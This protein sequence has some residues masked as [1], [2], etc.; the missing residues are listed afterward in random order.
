MLGN[1]HILFLYDNELSGE[2]PVEIDYSSNL[3]MIDFFETG[4][5]PASLGSCHQLTILDLVDDRSSGS[6]PATFGSLRVLELL[7]LYN[8]SLEGNLPDELINVANLTRISQVALTGEMPFQLSLCKKLTHLDL[9]NSLLFGPIP[10]WIGSLPLLGELKLSSNQFSGYLPRELFNCSKLLVQELSIKLS[11]SPG[12]TVAI[13]RIPRK[14]DLLLD[15]SL[16]REIRTLGRTRHRH[17]V[18][19]LGYCSNREA[20]SNLLIY[21][22]M[23]NGSS[24]D[25]LHKQTM[26]YKKKSLDWEVLMATLLQGM[27]IPKR[28]Q[29]RVMFT[30]WVLY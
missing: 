4:E 9:D 11:Y 27:L 18:K 20:G 29:K 24:W 3:Q 10:F 19:L 6:I 16:A 17:L 12:E 30:S 14:D 1:L 2:I 28:R 13:K 5:I 23:E 22:Y 15:R 25:W 7:M 26:S 21:E 8:N